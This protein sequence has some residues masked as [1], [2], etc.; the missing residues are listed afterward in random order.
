ME[1]EKGGE[2]E[3]ENTKVLVT[4]N[5][6][7]LYFLPLLPD[8]YLVGHSPCSYPISSFEF[9]IC[10][11]RERDISPNSL[12]SNPTSPP[13]K[14]RSKSSSSSPLPPLH[15]DLILIRRRLKASISLLELER[16]GRRCKSTRARQISS[17]PCSYVPKPWSFTRT[18]LRNS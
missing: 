16:Y 9:S 11:S 17:G 5:F 4:A 15:N 6:L 13:P 14:A 18:M 2:G 3:E 1:R 10:L 7:L 12:D 8:S